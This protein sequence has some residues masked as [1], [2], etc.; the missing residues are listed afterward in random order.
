MDISLTRRLKSHRRGLL[1]LASFRGCTMNRIRLC[2]AM[3]V[4]WALSVTPAGAVITNVV[5]TGGDNEATDT[6]AAKWTG[7]TWP[8]SVAGEP[9]LSSTVGTNYTVGAF[10]NLAPIF[11]DRAHQYLGGLGTTPAVP[12]YLV[13]GDYIM[14]GNDN[15]D[16]AA[17][18]LDVTI[19]SAASVYMLIDNRLSDTANGT[20]P[21]FDATHM[22]WIL[23]QGWV[24][25][26]NGFNRTANIAVPDEVGIDEGGNGDLNNWYSVYTKSY[27]AGTFSLFQPDAAGLNMYGVVIKS[28]VAPGDVD[29]DGDTDIFDFNA[30]R[31]HFQ[32][33]AT[34]RSQGDLNA[35][36]I[37]NFKDFRLWKGNPG[38]ESNSQGVPEPTTAL[39][40]LS[41]LATL[42]AAGRSRRQP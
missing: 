17:Y 13:G 18:K 34:L 29:S 28:G 10:A 36:G 40:G 26:N 6:I 22:Q 24:A 15:R 39:L 5:E 11:V 38:V 27:A 19:A 21:T 31:D 30:I 3:F 14:S 9:L 12:A 25:T 2:S 1:A 32:Q 33:P 8:V 41:V 35:D 42:C 37:V 23:D 7:T 16:N 20:P 4:L